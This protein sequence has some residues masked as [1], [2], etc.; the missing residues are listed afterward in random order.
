VEVLLRDDE[1]AKW[2]DREIARACGVGHPL[3]ADIRRSLTGIYSSDER[4]Y[5]TKH[6]TQAE[7]RTGNIG[8]KPK[9]EMETPAP[10]PK[11]DESPEAAAIVSAAQDWSRAQTVGNPQDRAELS[12]ASH[13]TQQM[14]DK[15]V[16]EAPPE[17]VKGIQ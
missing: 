16:K 10:E 14:A 11:A 8:G 9:T 2:S 15:L 5:T 1:W 17:L 4:T 12:G 3:V 7:M 13:R 6:G